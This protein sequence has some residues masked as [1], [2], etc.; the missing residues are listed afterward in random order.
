MNKLIYVD[1]DFSRFLGGIGVACVA[2]KDFS[3]LCEQLD[4]IVYFYTK[5]LFKYLVVYGGRVKPFKLQDDVSLNAYNK[6]MIGMEAAEKAKGNEVFGHFRAPYCLDIQYW[7]KD[8]I[9][10]NPSLQERKEN[11]LRYMAANMGTDIATVVNV[12]NNLKI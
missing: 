7:D 6:L 11:A 10:T 5:K 9:E 2:T 12:L 8:D 1:I 4:S 3:N